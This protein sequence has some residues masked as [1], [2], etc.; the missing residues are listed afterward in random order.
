MKLV[1]LTTFFVLIMVIFGPAILGIG[2]HKVTGGFQPSLVNVVD[3]YGDRV[4]EQNIYSVKNNFSGIGL[5][6]KNPNLLNTSEIYLDLTSAD[7]QIKR[8]S[9]LSGRNIQDGAL[10]TFNFDPI[11]DSEGKQFIYT[12][13]SSQTQSS[14][15]LEPFYTNDQ[16]TN[17]ANF[18]VNNQ[19]GQ[20]SLAQVSYYKV[21]NPVLIWLTIYRNWIWKLFQDLSFAILY[22]AIIFISVGYVISSVANRKIN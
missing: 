18:T 16:I 2:I 17:T 6:I 22:S 10:V 3:L 8:T 15:P 21:S 4:I 11:S 20:G 9:K 7:G 12:L 1:Y 14:A 5:S 13:K 19:P